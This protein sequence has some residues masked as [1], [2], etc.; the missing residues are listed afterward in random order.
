[1]RSLRKVG[2]HQ[3]SSVTSCCVTVCGGKVALNSMSTLDTRVIDAQRLPR[4][5]PSAMEIEAPPVGVDRATGS[6]VDPEAHRFINAAV[7]SHSHAYAVSKR[8]FDVTFAVIQ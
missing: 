6:I 1:M 5:G 7:E 8:A 4:T 2:K 3:I